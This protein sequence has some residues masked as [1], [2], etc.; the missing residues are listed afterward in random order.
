M[1]EE[2]EIQTVDEVKRIDYMKA[3]NDTLSTT[4]DEQSV[5]LENISNSLDDINNAIN[6]SNNISE[7][8]ESIDNIDMTVVESQTQDTL[9][10]VNNQ[11]QQIDTMQSDIQEIKQ[12]LNQLIEK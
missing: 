5:H 7:V 3:T 9:E 1:A 11:Q 12:L 2:I 4:I 6:A 10:L 8:I